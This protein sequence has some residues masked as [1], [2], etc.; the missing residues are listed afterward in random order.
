MH[1]AAAPTPGAF[2]GYPTGERVVYRTHPMLYMILGLLGGALL[3]VGAFFFLFRPIDRAPFVVPSVESRPADVAAAPNTPPEK[4]TPDAT[5]PIPELVPVPNPST[6][7]VKSPPRLTKKNTGRKNQAKTAPG[8]PGSPGS[9]FT[10]PVTM[11]GGGTTGTLSVDA[12]AGSEL[13]VDGKR[14]GV[15]PL[16]AVSLTAGP[17]R[18]VV[19]QAGTGVEYRRNI[20][21]KADLELTLTVQF[22]NN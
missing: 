9:D 16:D 17:H 22:Y 5:S 2:E 3:V 7:Q 21:V 12:P 18:I 4:A 1:M 11:G 10:E 8:T 15:M 14:I 6:D 19:K 20:T 13:F